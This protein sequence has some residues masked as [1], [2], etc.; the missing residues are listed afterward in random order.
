MSGSAFVFHSLA[1]RLFPGLDMSRLT[2][3]RS[4][5]SLNARLVLSQ[6]TACVFPP[7]AVALHL[8]QQRAVVT[9]FLV[10]SCSAG[11]AFPSPLSTSNSPC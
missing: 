11:R 10:P 6:A 4:S 7:A 1:T 5:E 9:R 2:H 3:G 8:K